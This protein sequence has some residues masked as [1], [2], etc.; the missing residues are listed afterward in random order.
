MRLIS[1]VGWVKRG[2]SQTPQAVRLEKEE[3]KNLFSELGG[4]N[5]DE[6]EEDVDEEEED[7]TSN[8]GSKSV[9][10]KYNMDNYDEEDDDVRIE[11][12]NS[13]ACFASNQEDALLSRKDDGEDSDEEDLE[14]S[15][16]DNLIVCGT[17]NGDD[18]SLDIYG[19]ITFKKPSFIN[20]Y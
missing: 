16:T 19:R 10:R 2:A 1:S 9:D 3:M 6:S 7:S 5:K 11:P 17:I 20:R 15:P 14:I 13:L 18:S 4:P 12:L 8:D